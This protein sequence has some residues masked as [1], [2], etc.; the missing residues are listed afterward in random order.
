V[1]AIFR[2]GVKYAEEV[3][4]S[5]KSCISIMF[6]GSAAGELGQ[7]YV[8]YK[9]KFCYP[10]WTENGPPG[11]IYSATLSGWFE[12]FTFCDWL[13]GFVRSIRR[14]RAPGRVLLIGDNLKTHHSIE[15][16]D[17][18]RENEIEL[19]CLPPNATDKIQPLDVG[20]FKSLKVQWRDMLRE[21]GT[22]NPEFKAL[23][24]TVF[25]KMLRELVDKLDPRDKLINAFEKCGLH[26]INPERPMEKI[27]TSMDAEDIA[28]GVDRELLKRLEIRR[29]GDP[30][31]KRP[32]GKGVPAG[33]SLSGVNQEEEDESE[34]DES[35]EDEEEEET[36]DESSRS[37]GSNNSDD[38]AENKEE[39]VCIKNKFTEHFSITVCTIPVLKYRMCS[40]IHQSSHWPLAPLWLLVTRDNSL[41][42]RSSETS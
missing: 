23:A 4:D 28:K 37:D 36:V 32:R 18:C 30:A 41:W 34:E 12:G 1:K 13:K 39:E 22:A 16:I 2:R 20:L 19:V 35:E 15:A 10:L 24:K 9:G 21:Y 26:P 8:V 42:R 6:V 17:I 33:A 14:T 5:S 25:P 29:F 7:L 40:R 31:K 11:C 3:R 38:E 27:P